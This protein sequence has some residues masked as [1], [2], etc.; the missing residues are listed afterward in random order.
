MV[1]LAYAGIPTPLQEEFATD[2]FLHGYKDKEITL[3]VMSQC[4]ATLTDAVRQV[5]QLECD[6]TF[7]HGISKD[8]VSKSLHLGRVT[9]LDENKDQRAND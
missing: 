2:V 6:Y 9:W 3:R 4:P 8:V 7:L 1:P 5:R